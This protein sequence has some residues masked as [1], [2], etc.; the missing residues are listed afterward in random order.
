MYGL[1]E[2]VKDEILTLPFIDEDV[3]VFPDIEEDFELSDSFVDALVV[4]EDVEEESEEDVEEESEEDVEEETLGIFPTIFAKSIK[5]NK[6]TTI[7]KIHESIMYPELYKASIAQ[8]T[9]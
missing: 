4:V 8:V 9:K 3:F 7:A 6:M 5:P 2:L 1:Y